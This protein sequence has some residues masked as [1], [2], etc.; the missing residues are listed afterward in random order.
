GPCFV[1]DNDLRL[2][3]LGEPVCNDPGNRVGP[4]ARRKGHDDAD[5][6]CRP[7]LRASDTRCG[8]QRGSAGGELQKFAARKLHRA[9]PL[10]YMCRVSGV[11]EYPAAS[12]RLNVG[13][14]DYLPPLFGVLDYKLA[15][16]ECRHRKRGD[17]KISETRFDLG[18]GEA[19]VDFVVE[20]ANDLRRSV[21]G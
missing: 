13:V 9:L 7:C 3:C 4:R 1:F 8:R 17:T 12:L 18:L 14:T 11:T 16:V 15:K 21:L 2:P 10:R 6:A 19:S 20:L 5:V